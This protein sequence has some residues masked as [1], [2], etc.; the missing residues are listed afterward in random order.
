MERYDGG[1]FLT[2]AGGS[3][4]GIAASVPIFSCKHMP[5]SVHAN[6]HTHKGEPQ[7]FKIS[8]ARGL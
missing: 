2:E 5:R 3:Q 8:R 1:H 6:D 4:E 7:L